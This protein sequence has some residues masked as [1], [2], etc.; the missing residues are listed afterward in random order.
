MFRY[1]N[2]FQFLQTFPETQ[3]MECPFHFTNS[4]SYLC[5]QEDERKTDDCFLVWVN[6]SKLTTR[7]VC[8]TAV[9]KKTTRRWQAV[10][11]IVLLLGIH[12][13]NIFSVRMTAESVLFLS[14]RHITRLVYDLVSHLSQYWWHF[15]HL[16]SNDYQVLAGNK[17]NYTNLLF[18]TSHSA[19]IQQCSN[20][21]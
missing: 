14:N 2:N 7:T 3:L 5:C 19:G 15:N 6:W 10:L 13:V 1:F 4:L 21:G 16:E 8:S 11:F 12:T 20:I 9:V 18:Q 17:M